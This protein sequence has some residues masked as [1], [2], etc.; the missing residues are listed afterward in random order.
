[1]NKNEISPYIRVAMH[2]TLTAPFVVE[3]R[4]IFDYEIILVSDGKCKIT[5]DGEEYLCKKNDI[6]FLR[7]GIPHKFESVGEEDFVQ[8]HI[9]FDVSYS[10]KSEKRFISYKTKEY[11]TTDE[12]NL[13][14][15]DVFCDMKLPFVF[16]LGYMSRFKKLF[17]EIIEIFQDKPYNYELLYKSEM[18]KL[19]DCLLTQFGGE[20]TGPSEKIENSVVMVKNYID[21]NF[22]NIIT[23]DSLSKQFYFN[24][25]TLIRK[26]R[27]MY[28]ENVI[29]YYRNKRLLYIKNALKTTNLS[30]TDLS[31]KLNFTDIYSFS[32]FFK[33]HTGYSPTEYRKKEEKLE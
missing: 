17:F 6:V 22:L 31:E 23:L 5:I 13:I 28:R 16:T 33:T 15:D 10:E 8:P 21:N 25:Y 18:L 7:P 12:L 9:H 14:Q 29:A 20:R 19:I 24:K 3:T 32:R 26:F 2:S 11:M 30:V 27:L 4:V 1:M